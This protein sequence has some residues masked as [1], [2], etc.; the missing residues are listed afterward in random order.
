MKLF[1]FEMSY[2]EN[3]EII[4]NPK[5][6]KGYDPISLLYE[7][8]VQ[9]Y[10]LR[11]VTARLSRPE[12]TRGGKHSPGISAFTGDPALPSHLHP[13]LLLFAPLVINPLLHKPP[14]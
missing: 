10:I 6:T 7:A 5:H 12:G 11:C 9:H 8:C 2:A 13:F 3:V 1:H 14:F 4:Q